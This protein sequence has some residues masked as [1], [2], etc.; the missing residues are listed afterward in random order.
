STAA[1]LAPGPGRATWSVAG[2]PT[3]G[4]L[5]VLAA[6]AGVDPEG[7]REASPPLR[8]VPF[9]SI[10]KRMSSLHRSPDGALRLYIKGAP[11]ELLARSTRVSR[12]GAPEPFDEAG[13]AAIA[14]RIDQA[15]GKG[16][17]V[18]GF[19]YRDF[20]SDPGESGAEALERELTFVGFVAMHD[21][22]RPGVEEA[23]ARCREAGIRVLMLTGDFGPTAL[24]IARRIGLVGAGPARAVTGE[25]LAAMSDA[26]LEAELTGGELVFARISPEHKLR[27]VGRLQALGEVVAVTGDGVNDAP[28]LR[29]ADIGVA[30]GL[31]G[32]DVARESAEMVLTDDDFSSIVAAVEE[33]RAVYANLRKFIT[34]IFAHLV[35]EAVPFVLFAFLSI[36]VPITV[37]LIL[38]IDLGTETLPALA[39]GVER[40]E[41]G[42]MQTQPRARTEHLVD[43]GVLARG[44][45]FLG[46]LNAAGVMAAYFIVLLRGGWSF[47]EQLEPNPATFA[48]PLHLQAMTTV[49]CGIVVMQIANLF[50]CRSA[51]KSVFEIGLF[52]NRLLWWGL[53]FEVAFMLALVYVPAL[54]RVFGT[55]ALGPREWALLVGLAALVFVAEEARKRIARARRERRG[56]SLG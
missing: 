41:P 27:I 19:A 54:Q 20:E 10:R 35:P 48:N 4:A 25:Q 16:F 21:P 42:V 38:A 51:D 17:R 24:A 6:K 2:D 37:L 47:G 8:R 11:R 26:Q 14:A 13:R 50:A 44:Y 18:L 53:G 15:A 30:M 34:Y 1:L 40:P 7:A 56:R 46:L 36:P 33:G 5:L 43:R 9:D 39:L 3:E 32:S 12:G 22:P 49:F 45:G 52:G 29:K 28:A 31:R 55:A 23:I